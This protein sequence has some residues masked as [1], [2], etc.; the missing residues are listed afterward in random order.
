M[1]TTYDVPPDLLID[2]V[3]K[4]L[5]EEAKLEPPEWAAF[6]KTGV[7]KKKSPTNPDWWFFR[8]ASVLRKIY[9]MGPIGSSRLAS[10]FGGRKDDGSAPY[11]PKKG[12]RAIMRHCLMQLEKLGLLE[13]TNKGRIISPRGR[14]LL[15]NTSHEIMSELAKTNPELTK[16]LGKTG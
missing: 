4:Y 7:H 13:K 1:T 16:Y 6:A 2:K 8:S 5:K 10:E 12:S 14:S 15:D 11:H 3:A 9:I